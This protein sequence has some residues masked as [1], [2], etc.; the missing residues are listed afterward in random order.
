MIVL[1]CGVSGLTSA[2]V[3]LES[4]YR[5]VTIWAK[6]L[7][8]FTTSNIAAAIWYPYKIAPQQKAV[9]WGRRSYEIFLTLAGQPGTGVW[10]REGLEI[11]PAEMN[12]SEGLPEWVAFVKNFRL[13]TSPDLPVGYGTG[14]VF[15]TPVIETRLY[16]EYLAGRVRQLGGQIIQKEVTSLAEPLENAGIV[17]NCSGL[18]SRAMLNDQ[19]VYPIRGQI[20]R[21]EQ[22][23]DEGFVLAEELPDATGHVGTSYV[24]PRSTDCVVGGTSQENNWSLEPDPA[25]AEDI[26]Q[27]AAVYRPELK[28]AR[29]LEHLVGLRPGRSSVRLEAE[30]LADG[31]LVVHNYGHGGAG[32]TV[33][34]GCAEEVVS[35]VGKSKV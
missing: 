3:L 13:A 25:T 16:L 26:L 23:L 12:L 20:V 35:L 32:V 30:T 14:Y 6:D 19:A 15:D 28:S 34:W 27:R 7:P 18:G 2:L 4:G 29:V 31:K 11:F 33:S 5:S 24:V 17:I 9:E 10:L 1:G 21:V 8:P 22:Q